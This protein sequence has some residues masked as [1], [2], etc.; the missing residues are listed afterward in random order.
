M[1]IFFSEAKTL[2]LKN[3]QKKNLLNKN[4]IRICNGFLRRIFFCKILK[5]NTKFHVKKKSAKLDPTASN[6]TPR[7]RGSIH[8]QNKWVHHPLRPAQ[9]D[10]TVR[11][12][13][14]SAIPPCC[15]TQKTLQ[16][17]PLP[18]GTTFN[19]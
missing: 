17:I 9:L 13:G 10:V 2:C 7:L 11:F 16:V 6:W 15:I 18:K 19:F 8:A 3:S 1:A 12:G 14:W 4:M 5:Q